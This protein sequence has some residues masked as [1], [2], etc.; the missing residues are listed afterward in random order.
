[1]NADGEATQLV[2]EP[3]STR[4]GPGSVTVDLRKAVNGDPEVWGPIWGRYFDRLTRLAHG[5]MAR[6][7]R[8]RTVSDAEDVAAAALES[9]WRGIA[10]GRFAKLD[11]RSDLW[12]LLATIA[13][14]KTWR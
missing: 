7:G 14:R 3:D 11:D 8:S 13:F 10:R 4:D 9:V 12:R 2:T 6:G 1:M 5:M